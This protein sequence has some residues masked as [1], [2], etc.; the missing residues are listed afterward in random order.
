VY[1]DVVLYYLAFVL[2]YWPPI[3]F[4]SPQVIKYGFLSPYRWS[5]QPLH[6]HERFEVFSV[7]RMMTIFFWVL[8]LHRLFSRCQR[9]AEGSCFLETVTV[10]FF[11]VL[12]IY[13]CL[14]TVQ[15]PRR[16]SSPLW[17]LKISTHPWRWKQLASAYKS[18]QYQNQRSDFIIFTSVYLQPVIGCIYSHQRPWGAV[19]AVCWCCLC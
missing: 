1:W 8:T 15:K 7:A 19:A 2:V 13:Q 16:T 5:V 9:S 12:S 3:V 14:Y 6:I 10:H 4:Q 11:K 17:N 18:A